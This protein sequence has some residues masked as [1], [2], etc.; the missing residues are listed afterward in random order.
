M[1]MQKGKI[2]TNPLVF[3]YF[4]AVVIFFFFIIVI[5]IKISFVEGHLGLQIGT[6]F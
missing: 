4:P 2:L 3:K 5:K 1:K 6:F